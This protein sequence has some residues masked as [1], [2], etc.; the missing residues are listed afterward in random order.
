MCVVD[1]DIDISPPYLCS[2]QVKCCRPL[3]AGISMP[4]H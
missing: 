2:R 4:P 1:T 3:S